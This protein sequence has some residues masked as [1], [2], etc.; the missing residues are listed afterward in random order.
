MVSKYLA[1]R[2]E[3]YRK[4]LEAKKEDETF[5]DVIARLLEGKHDLMAFAGILSDD[6]ESGRVGDVIQKVRKKTVLRN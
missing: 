2:E 5:N 4:L 3:V 6:K 1:V